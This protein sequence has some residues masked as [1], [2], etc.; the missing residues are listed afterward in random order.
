MYGA[1]Y[2]PLKSKI[3]RGN[4]AMRLDINILGLETDRTTENKPHL[5]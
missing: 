2:S 4:A 1:D 5:C 3:E